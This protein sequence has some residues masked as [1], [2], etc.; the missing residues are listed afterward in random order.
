MRIELATAER[1]EED[2]VRAAVRSGVAVRI[3]QSMDDFRRA[4]DVVASVWGTGP[5]NAQM[6]AE[7]IRAL[8]HAGGYAAGAFD[9]GDLVGAVIAFLGRDPEGIFLHS[10]ILGVRPDFQARS[11]GFALK[12]HQRAWSLA[13][14]LRRVTWTFD[15][16]VRR[17]AYF[18][19]QKLA[20]DV[21]EYHANFY[22]AMGD[23]INAGDESDR[24]LA[25]W[26]LD[27]PEVVAAAGTRR[28]DP[29]IDRLVD[30]G[31]ARV[32]SADDRG[33]PQVCAGRTGT[34]LCE[35]P[36]DI[37]GLRA[38][39]PG[40]AFGW[41]RALRET[42]GASMDDGYAVKGISRSGWYVLTR[43]GSPA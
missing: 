34:I 43:D 1:A 9:G 39:D 5:A 36:S 31:A 26:Y 12:E 21:G 35:V 38:A 29:D 6:P 42:L 41:R 16:L 17:N 37:I 4:D 15:P 11:I 3:L 28:T 14:G 13:Q 22:G 24:V 8:T 7:L 40:L 27:D 30:R 33:R 20:A 19:L 18:N 23:G 32:L 10:H 25:T 2:A